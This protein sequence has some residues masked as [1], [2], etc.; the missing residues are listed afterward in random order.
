MVLFREAEQH[1]CSLSVY[2]PAYRDFRL[3]LDS[4]H[5]SVAGNGIDLFEA[6]AEV[7]RRLEPSGWRIAV[8]GSRRQAFASGLMRDM[9]GAR[10]VYL[11]EPG[12][13]PRRGNLVDIF[14]EAPIDEIA[15]VD[16]QAAW[17]R[18]WLR[19]LHA[20]NPEA[21]DSPRVVST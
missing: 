7:R 17:L 9:H 15:T 5:G 10:R 6:L 8:H 21:Q 20:P 12:R 19:A 16:E 11:C 2:T 14:G 4:P 1:R 13:W 3:V 18:T